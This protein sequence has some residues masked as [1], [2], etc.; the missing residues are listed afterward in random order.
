VFCYE[1]GEAELFFSVIFKKRES[2]NTAQS[3]LHCSFCN[4]SLRYR[5]N[6]NGHA[7]WQCRKCGTGR[8]WPMPDRDTINKFYAGF[9]FQI[10]TANKGLTTMAAGK[11]YKELHLPANGSLTML[12]VGGG[13]GF[14][15]KAFEELGYGNAV[16]VDLDQQ[17][18]EFAKDTLGL[19]SVYHCDAGEIGNCTDVRFDL[20]YNRHLIE[21][22]IDPCGFLEKMM[23][24]LKD[25]GI[26]VTHFP[27][28][29]S[30]EYLAYPQR[31]KKRFI[32]IR[33]T[34]KYS[35]VKTVWKLM[36]GQMLHGIDPIRH[37]WAISS[38]GIISWAHRRDIKIRTYTAHLG[39]RTYSPYYKRAA[40]LNGKIQDFLG[41][42]IL[43]GIAG[44]THLIAILTKQ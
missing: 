23:E 33:N 17:A 14:F 44:G 6:M 25:R 32:S 9:C 40:T 29:E 3:G 2:M 35:T 5:Y 12:D 28:G 13:G 10:D 27:N 15:A 43:S 4:S 34:N 37:L 7:I 18:C 36:D 22:L 30:L 1:Q 20:I 41:Q 39:D 19:R 26:L 42:C 8:V 31:L 11:L 21:H 24:L 16:Y 38:K